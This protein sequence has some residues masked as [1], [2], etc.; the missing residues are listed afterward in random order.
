MRL[1]FSRHTPRHRRLPITDAFSLP[2]DFATPPLAA[3]YRYTARYA[4]DA[5]LRDLRC[6][7]SMP[8]SMIYRYADFAAIRFSMLLCFAYFSL[9]TP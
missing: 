1:I 5:T 6:R 8:A 9:F 2:V 3:R 7:L 4:D